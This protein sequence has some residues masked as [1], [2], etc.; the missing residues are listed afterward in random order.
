MGQG[1]GPKLVL[2]PGG[3]SMGPHPAWEPVVGRV[4]NAKGVWLTAWSKLECALPTTGG[5]EASLHCPG[6]CSNRGR[7]CPSGLVPA[8]S[9]S[10]LGNRA[11]PCMGLAPNIIPG[12]GPTSSPRA[13]TDA[14]IFPPLL[15]P[16]VCLLST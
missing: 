14:S 16:F 5:E 10:G 8:G 13:I 15:A 2:R 6:S 1:P 4:V 3:L 12:A 9:A 11:V 7:G